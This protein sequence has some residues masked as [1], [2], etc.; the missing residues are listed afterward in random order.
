MLT[1]L[2][3][4]IAP[5]NLPPAPQPIALHAPAPIAQI[6][7]NPANPRINKLFDLQRDAFIH[8]KRELRLARS[9]R[10]TID[11]F[12][13]YQEWGAAIVEVETTRGAQTYQVT[14]V[15]QW[16]PAGNGRWDYRGMVDGASAEA[17]MEVG[18]PA[19]NAYW[20]AEFLNS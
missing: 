18:M 4:S 15:M 8:A 11:R 12:Q 1:T 10:V 6:L 5:V 17:F 16:N 14:I 3:L 13:G 7:T 2:L 20:T 9:A 19:E